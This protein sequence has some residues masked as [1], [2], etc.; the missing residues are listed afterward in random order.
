MIAKADI[1]KVQAWMGHAQI[2]TTQR[3]L[4]Y[5]ERPD[6]VALLADAFAIKPVVGPHGQLSFGATD[7]GIARP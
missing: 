1:L 2:S 5:V 4:H 7:G 6:E 3:Y